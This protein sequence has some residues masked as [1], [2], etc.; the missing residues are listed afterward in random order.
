MKYI[1]CMLVFVRLF[2]ANW[3]R[4]LTLFSFIEL[5][6]SL[7]WILDYFIGFFYLLFIRK[8]IEIDDWMKSVFKYKF[9]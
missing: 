3:R 5:F 1:I 6:I 9:D 7:H 8:V 2:L 4:F